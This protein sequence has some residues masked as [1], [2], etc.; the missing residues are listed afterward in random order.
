MGTIIVTGTSRTTSGGISLWNQICGVVR[1]SP[2][3]T[4]VSG[5]ARGIDT[6]WLLASFDI[7]AGAKRVLVVP[8][9]VGAFWNESLTKY[10]SEII[11]AK[12]GLTTSESF[13]SQGPDPRG[14]HRSDS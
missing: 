3:D 5:G 10:V 13:M 7:W 8:T 14:G 6:L 9:G 1:A 12:P 2:A 4:Y 11:Q